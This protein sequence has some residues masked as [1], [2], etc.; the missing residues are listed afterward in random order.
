MG[1]ETDSEVDMIE[2]DNE[3]ES[4]E[5]VEEEEASDQQE[6]IS[7]TSQSMVV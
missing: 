3:D 1:S 6:P 5:L 7:E 4:D 2:D